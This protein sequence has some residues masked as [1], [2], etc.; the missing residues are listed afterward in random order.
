MFILL[1]PGPTDPKVAPNSVSYINICLPLDFFF[2]FIFQDSMNAVFKKKIVCN[3]W[4]IKD[5]L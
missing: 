5:Q 1:K 4:R 3:C 2:L